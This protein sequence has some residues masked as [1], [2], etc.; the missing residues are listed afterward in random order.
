MSL[1]TKNSATTYMFYCSEYLHSTALGDLL[2]CVLKEDAE[3]SR[4]K[5]HVKKFQH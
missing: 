5:L 3:N 2:L 1:E 4:G